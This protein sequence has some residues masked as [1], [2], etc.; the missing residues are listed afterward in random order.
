M[1]KS[2]I[3]LASFLLHVGVSSERVKKPNVI[4]VLA[5]DLGWGDVSW[6]NPDMPTS[7]MARLAAEGLRLEQSYAQQVCTPSRAALL[8]GR[9][10]FHIGRQKRALKPLQPTGL[11]LNVTTLPSELKKLGYRTHMVGK[12]HLGYCAWE[13]TPTRRGFDT[14][15]GHYLGSQNHFSHD[16]DYKTHPSDPPTFYDFRLNEDIAR[17]GYEGVYST[18]IFKQRSLDIIESVAEERD[19]N[20]YGNYKPFFLYLSLQAPHAPLQ[21]RA[22]ILAT[23][24]QTSNPARDIYKAMIKDVDLAL[25]EIVTSLRDRGLDNDTIIVVTSD[26][27]GAISHGASNFPLRGTKGTLFE[28]GTRVPTFVHGPE[29]LLGHRGAVTTSLVHITDWMPSILR[30]AGYQGD[31]SADLGL[32]GVDQT[33]VLRDGSNVRKEMVYNLK[34]DPISGAL[35]YGKYKIIFGKKFNKQGWYNTDNTALQCSRMMKNKKEKRKEEQEQLMNE[36]NGRVIELET[37]KR[38]DKTL[39]TP[40]ANPSSNNKRPKKEGLK[41]KKR[42]TSRKKKNSKRKKETAAKRNISAEKNKANRNNKKK[43]RLANKREKARE[44]KKKKKQ[45]RNKKTERAKISK[46]IQKESRIQKSDDRERK[47]HSRE[48]KR[49]LKK[50]GKIERKIEKIWRD[51]LPR[52]SMEIQNMLRLRMDQC[53]WKDF[54]ESG[55]SEDLQLI[56]RSAFQ[57]GD[58]VQIMDPMLNPFNIS[59]EDEAREFEDDDYDFVSLTKERKDPATRKA[60]RLMERRFDNLDI[61]MY[62]VVDDPEE[63]VDLRFD[64]PEIFDDLKRRALKHLENVVPEDFPEQDFSGH[65]RMFGGVFSPGW[66]KP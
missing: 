22:E 10:P 3:A 53:N 49:K 14:F 24:P 61:A 42:Q 5:D 46:R 40:E 62:N 31:P 63:R 15:L 44:N 27:G 41:K 13:Y 29:H 64:L 37:R 21:A 43:Q 66:C 59:S 60:E 30:L 65:P 48:E 9:Y 6:N 16:R 20:A 36:R 35:R 2:E 19:L 17:K 34:K 47:Q 4:F 7:N 56:P 11:T 28:G 58:I 18:T 25:G 12:W 38:I 52:P 33:P 55:H 26:N 1:M 54:T 23:I 39:V 50:E 57:V 51:W 8:T 32:D 45:Q